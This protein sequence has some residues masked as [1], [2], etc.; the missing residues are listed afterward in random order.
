MNLLRLIYALRVL[1]EYG[2][3][4]G[5]SD[6]E[7]LLGE[8]IGGDSASGWSYTLRQFSAAKWMVV[9]SGGSPATVRTHVARLWSLPRAE[10]E[11]ALMFDSDLREQLFT[12]IE[13]K[14]YEQEPFSSISRKDAQVDHLET[15][16]RKSNT[17][18]DKAP[19]MTDKLDILEQRLDAAVNLWRMLDDEG[20]AIDSL[21]LH[22]SRALAIALSDFRDAEGL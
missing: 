20:F 17:L 6:I 12:P 4:W 5:Y 8:A 15:L 2:V 18:R 3:I 21:H 22:R 16:A 14:K 19:A 13:I 9:K 1:N 7:G 10:S 11:V